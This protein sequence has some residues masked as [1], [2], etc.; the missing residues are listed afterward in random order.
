MA[1]RKRNRRGAVVA[2]DIPHR[3]GDGTRLDISIEAVF[4]RDVAADHHAHQ[5]RHAQPLQVACLHQPP[6]AQHRYAVTDLE[7]LVQTV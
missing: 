2:P 4:I 3:Q 7:D 1:H 6:V 5:M